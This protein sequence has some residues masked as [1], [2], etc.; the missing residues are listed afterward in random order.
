MTFCRTEGEPDQRFENRLFRL[1]FP[2]L[3][4]YMMFQSYGSTFVKERGQL[5]NEMNVD[6]E[7]LVHEHVLHIQDCQRTALMCK[8]C[9]R[10]WNTLSSQNQ[11]VQRV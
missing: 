8:K 9:V 10:L 11:P 7:E 2:S 4:H 6:D 1:F 3:A 5:K